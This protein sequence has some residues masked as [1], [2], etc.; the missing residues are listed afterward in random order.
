MNSEDEIDRVGWPSV[1]AVALTSIAITVNHVYTLGNGAFPLGTVLLF[2]PPAMWVWFRK[3][4]NPW[5]LAVYGAMNAWIVAGF[6]FARGL[7]DITLPIFAGTWLS[8]VSTAYPKPMFGVF[9]VG[10][11]RVL[12]V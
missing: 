3:T 2:V 9:G 4:G 10:T 7:W 11:R 5:A 12:R 1:V 6:G 8:A